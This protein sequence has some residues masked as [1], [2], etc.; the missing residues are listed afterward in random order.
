MITHASSRLP[1]THR[2][3][4]TAQ[5]L[6]HKTQPEQRLDWGAIFKLAFVLTGGMLAMYVVA[7]LFF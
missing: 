6:R 5:R 2:T 4:T 1:V 3:A 7:V